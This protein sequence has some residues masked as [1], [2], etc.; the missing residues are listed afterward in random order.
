M[1]LQDE[2]VKLTVAVNEQKQTIDTMK[3]H[4]EQQAAQV[5]ELQT[6]LNAANAD[7]VRLEKTLREHDLAALARDNPKL[8]EDKMNKA[9]ARVWRDLEATTGAAPRQDSTPPK[10]ATIKRKSTFKKLE[11]VNAPAQ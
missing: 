10:D 6:G 9:T 5:Q 4:A 3:E 1:A 8:I 11:D 7:K 2:N